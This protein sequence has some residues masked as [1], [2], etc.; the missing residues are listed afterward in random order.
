MPYVADR[1]ARSGKP[2]WSLRSRN[3]DSLKQPVPRRSSAKLEM[4]EAMFNIACDAIWKISRRDCKLR[5]VRQTIVAGLELLN[6]AS[7]IDRSFL[8]KRLHKH[9]L[10]GNIA[11]YVPLGHDELRLLN[12]VKA[13]VSG[14]SLEN[15][16]QPQIM[17]LALLSAA[18]ST[19]NISETSGVA[20]SK[21]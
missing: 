13:L 11:V 12:S 2:P 4:N 8:L 17:V 20:S 3:G 10:H 21:E 9:C 1:S 5:S 15:L 16:T 6:A 7:A 14:Q 18:Q 19:P